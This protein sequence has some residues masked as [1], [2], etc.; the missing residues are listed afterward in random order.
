MVL[1]IQG[2]KTIF[3]SHKELKETAAIVKRQGDIIVAKDGSGD[4]DSIR[5]ALLLVAEG[6][7][8]FIKEG[9]F[10]EDSLI[11]TKS[12]IKII[13]SGSNTIMHSTALSNFFYASGRENIVI[14]SINF[15]CT[16]NNNS[17]NYACINL[18]GCQNIQIVNCN[19]MFGSIAI[20]INESSNCWI[21]NC[22]AEPM[23]SASIQAIYILSSDKI[24]VQAMQVLNA[25]YVVYL[26]TAQYC[27]II[28]NWSTGCTHGYSLIASD[29][30]YLSGNS[31][32]ADAST[33]TDIKLDSD[34]NF[35]VINGNHCLNDGILINNAN[36]DKNIIVGN[37]ATITDSGTG[38]VSAN[39]TI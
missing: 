20:K 11:I 28:N 35:N 39:N 5:E 6:Q 33:S 13:G 26:D 2:F 37:V 25:D 4:T 24:F 15:N 19:F 21:T 16:W 23:D 34:S 27:K 7:I 8:I 12:N 10:Y 36:C 3:G 22:F 14:D 30:N 32:D 17:T 1:N 29:Y 38:T 9:A 31:Q 18:T